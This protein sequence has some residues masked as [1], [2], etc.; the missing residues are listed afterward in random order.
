M[1]EA[2]RRGTLDQRI[3][4]AKAT[5]RAIEE[6]AKRADL[7]KQANMTDV[8][9]QASKLQQRR[10]NSLALMMA[11]ALSGASVNLR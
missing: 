11:A 5:Q 9:K 8:E 7:E 3:S 4:D 1:G 2:K 10:S 6:A